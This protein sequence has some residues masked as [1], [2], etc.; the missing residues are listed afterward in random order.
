VVITAL[1]DQ[2][3]EHIGFAKV[4]RDLTERKQHEE[5]LREANTLLKN[6]QVELERLNRTKDEF[7]SLASHQLRTPAT[8]TK[9]FLGMLLEGFAGE[10]PPSQRS[11]V[12]KA[13]DSNEHQLQVV[14]NLLRVAQVDDGRVLLHRKPTDVSALIH[15]VVDAQMDSFT[16]RQQQISIK[17]SSGLRLVPLDSEH[18]RMALENLVDNASKYTPVGGKI[19]IG[20]REKDGSLV[21]TIKDTGVG[22]SSVDRDKLFKKFSRIPN[23]LSEAVGGSGLGLYWV[24]KI[25]HLHHGTISVT[26]KP[27]EGTTFTIRLPME[28]F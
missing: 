2:T 11:F 13:Y 21:L 3:G 26:S 8:G 27:D 23:Q 24:E 28:E 22:I 7:I 6:Q 14:N 9:Q 15:E 20:V 1:Y 10:V 25:I 5:N 16:R 17:V 12:Q 18:F 4:T 19:S